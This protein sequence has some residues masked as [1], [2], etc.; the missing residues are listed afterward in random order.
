MGY[1]ETVMSWDEATKTRDLTS[2]DI[3]HC[4]QT[5]TIGLVEDDEDAQEVYE[6]HYKMMVELMQRYKAAEAQAEIT[7]PIAEKAGIQK[8]M[9]E[10]ARLALLSDDTTLKSYVVGLLSQVRQAFLKEVEK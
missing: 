6:G 9:E 7:G 10:I 5:A 2:E 1:K 4:E 8:V 3:F